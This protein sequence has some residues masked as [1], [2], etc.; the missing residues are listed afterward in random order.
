[1]SL[2][3]KVVLAL[4]SI[5]SIMYLLGYK[6]LIS[7]TESL[8]YTLFLQT[9]KKE[10]TAG[11]IVTFKYQ[12]KNYFKYTQGDN[13]TKIIGCS[14]GQTI[15]RIKNDFYCNGGMIGTALTKD[16]KGNFI[17][18]VDFNEIVPQGKYFMIGT[19]PKSYDSKY[20]GYVDEKDILGVTYG[21]L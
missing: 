14:Q 21:I 15:L 1:M 7:N 17:E 16:G 13:F 19:N 6:I 3:A 4:I 9:P 5:Y 2:K 18:S 12:F 20:F 10:F 8:P 11:S